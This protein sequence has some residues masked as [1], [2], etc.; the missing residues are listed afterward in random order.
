MDTEE[1]Q[2]V[3][4][5]EEI[6]T[7]AEKEVQ[8]LLDGYPDYMFTINMLPNG[9]NME[10]RRSRTYMIEVS[11]SANKI[12]NSV[13]SAVRHHKITITSRQLHPQL[14]VRADTVRETCNRLI[15]ENAISK[16]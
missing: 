7:R 15:L 5:L 11:T 4:R 2:A 13:D 9:S 8:D 14:F 10:M 16:L 3:A 1:R 6:V 12:L